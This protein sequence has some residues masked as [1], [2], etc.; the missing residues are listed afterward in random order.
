[1]NLLYLMVL[2]L[3]NVQPSAKMPKDEVELLYV[4]Q[5]Q[6]DF[7]DD[8]IFALDG[9]IGDLEEYADE[10]DFDSSLPVWSI[11]PLV[12]LA[13]TSVIRP[14]AAIMNV[15]AT[16]GGGSVTLTSN[17]SIAPGIN[18]QILVLRGSHAT[19]TIVL[20]DNNGMKLAGNRTLA[21]ND[22]LTLYYDGTVTN[23]RIEIARSTNG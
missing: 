20:T 8:E 15:A 22:T 11:S 12:I 21:L 16:V 5:E 14:D 10:A 23:S 19:D 2:T 4:E 13:A 18:G 7:E 9:D 6:D 17:P 3:R 1:M